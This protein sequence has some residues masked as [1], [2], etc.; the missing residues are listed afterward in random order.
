MVERPVGCDA[1]WN[2]V[3]RCASADGD[4]PSSRI[5]RGLPSVALFATDAALGAALRGKFPLRA[6][7]VVL[8][9]WALLRETIPSVDCLVVVHRAVDSADVHRLLDDLPDA[10]A[11]P[12][13]ICAAPVRG[14]EGELPRC[15]AAGTLSAGAG[16]PVLWGEVQY[17]VSVGLLDRT[18]RRLAQRLAQ[19]R[20]RS[21]L[22]D[23]LEVL[24]TADPPPSS[25]RSLCRIV[26]VHRRTL[27]YQWHACIRGPLP[28][29]EDAM[30]S[31]LLLRASM[32]RARGATWTAAAAR[33]DLHRHTLARIAGRLA[34]LD[35]LPARFGSE[36]D[37][38]Y[39]AARRI[40]VENLVWPVLRQQ[41]V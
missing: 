23:A 41:T 34:G 40:V 31:V 18:V 11:V 21:A 30:A 38:A 15:T 6:S 35:R 29:L 9:S 10:P 33:L 32:R 7:I 16:A 4:R 1:A 5:L 27:W 19:T 36:A 28:R 8:T 26:G 2:A 37:V 24:C 17:A 25:I 13:V 20:P 22:R 14:A 3:D 39:A 12:T